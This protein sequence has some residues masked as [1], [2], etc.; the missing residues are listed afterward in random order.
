MSPNCAIL[1]DVWVLNRALEPGTLLWGQRTSSSS[2]QDN[3]FVSDPLY[4][5]KSNQCGAQ[6]KRRPR[7][8]TPLPCL[9]LLLPSESWSYRRVARRPA[10][11]VVSGEFLMLA[12]L[13]LSWPAFFTTEPG[14]LVLCPL[15]RP[16]PRLLTQVPGLHGACLSIA[17]PNINRREN[18]AA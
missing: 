4:K 8:P 1:P 5:G 13:A 12:C 2:G 16:L 11:H 14:C 6:T 9:S 15:P 3:T 18:R 7:L 17:C 10:W